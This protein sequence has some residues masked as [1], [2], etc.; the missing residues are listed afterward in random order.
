MFIVSK[1]G[2]IVDIDGNSAISYPN[3]CGRHVFADFEIVV[4]FIWMEFRIMQ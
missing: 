4:R 2:Y 3:V 1:C